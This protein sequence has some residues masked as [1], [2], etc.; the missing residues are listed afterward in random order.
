MGGTGDEGPDREQHDATQHGLDLDG[1]T[2][3]QPVI[4]WLSSA[5]G[6][7]TVPR[8]SHS[9]K[10]RLGMEAVNAAMS[11]ALREL[12]A[13]QCANSKADADP[14]RSTA[15]SSAAAVLVC[16]VLPAEPIRQNGS[17]NA[18][19]GGTHRASLFPICARIGVREIRGAPGFRAGLCGA[20][21]R[22]Q[23]DRRRGL[24]G[25][26]ESLRGRERGRGQLEQDHAMPEAQT[27]RA[28]RE[29]VCGITD[30]GCLQT[31]AP[32]LQ[33]PTRGCQSELQRT[34]EMWRLRFMTG[35]PRQGAVLPAR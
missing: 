1:W 23:H 10:M 33:G 32:K 8:T 30:L 7:L 4:D 25:G 35:R 6:I 18:E 17:D 13:D 27:Q 15:E 28:T 12:A 22:G 20:V 2:E 5:N 21:K 19:Y 26:G 11:L 3:P 34:G 9:D 29:W 31:S 24:P 16:A 14:H